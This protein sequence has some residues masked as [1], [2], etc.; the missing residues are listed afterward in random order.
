MPAGY[1]IGDHRLLVI[2]FAS[3]DIVGD[4]ALKVV[5]PASRRLNTKIPRTA[6]EYARLLEEKIIQHQL[7]ERIGKAYSKCRSKSSLTQH[8]N[9]MDKELGQYMR[10]AEKKCR[11]FKFGRIPFLPES[12]LWIRQTQ[13]YRSLLKYH[14]GHVQNRGNLNRS[15]RRCNIPDAFLITIQEVYFCLKACQNMCGYFRKHGHYY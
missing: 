13:V 7:I 6:A 1:G 4:T 8:L 15:A 12:S 5:R 11:K 2:D 3:R 10:F 14:A 9:K